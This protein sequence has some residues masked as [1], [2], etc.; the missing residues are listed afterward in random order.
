MVVASSKRTH[1]YIG[2]AFYTS[3]EVK[4]AVKIYAIENRREISFDKNDKNRVKAICNGTIPNLSS[5]TCGGP[6][7]GST[8]KGK[9]VRSMTRTCPWVLYVSKWREEEEWVV[10][11]FNDNHICLQYRKIKACTTTYVCNQIECNPTIPL[12]AVQEELERKYEIGVSQM[13]AHRAKAMAYNQVMGDY[14]VHYGILRDYALEL[15]A[16]NE[17][18]TV[19]IDVV[20]EPNLSNMKTRVFRRIYICIESLKRGF[21]AGK[22]DMLGLDGCFKKGPYPGQILTAMV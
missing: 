12:K 17:D 3:K 9:G 7:K 5:I 6:S 2:Q 8:V 15:Q 11:T 14:K 1:F 20:D 13:K 22:R 16:R 18:T 19:K 4:E 21:Q 10:K